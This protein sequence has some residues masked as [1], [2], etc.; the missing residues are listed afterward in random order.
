MTDK[1]KED[2]RARIVLGT[3]VGF[4]AGAVGGMF[5]GMEIYSE[6][7]VSVP[8][9]RVQEGFVQPSKLELELEDY[10]ENGEDEF[11]LKYNGKPYY[12]TVNE[13]DQPVIRPYKVNVTPRKVEVEVYEETK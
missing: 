5:A 10:D 7:H 9:M 13:Q 2:C 11:I 1:T 12:L 8:A 6:V 3:I 4:I